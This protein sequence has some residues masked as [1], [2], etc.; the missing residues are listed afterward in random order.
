MCFVRKLSRLLG[1]KVV[2][3]KCAVQGHFWYQLLDRVVMPRQPKA[4]VAIVTKMLADQLLWSPANTVIFYA[5]LAFMEGNLSGIPGILSEKLVPTVLAGYLLWPLAHLINFK[6]IPS[7]HRL[8][9]VNVINLF[10]SIYLARA[11][12]SSH[13]FAN[14]IHENLP[15]TPIPVSNLVSPPALLPTA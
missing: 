9:Y 11:A 15:V 1:C 10:W 7:R 12:N 5:S 2:I 6:F 13:G 14:L 3:T 4:T 8:L